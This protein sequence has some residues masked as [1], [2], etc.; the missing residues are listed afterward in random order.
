MSR[1]KYETGG[2]VPVERSWPD[3]IDE[4]SQEAAENKKPA[5]GYGNTA[6]VSEDEEKVRHS[7]GQNPPLSEEEIDRDANGSDEP[8]YVVKKE[9][10]RD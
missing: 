1:D 7:E 8:G 6:P 9:P 4:F 5:A 3:P 2:H 10:R